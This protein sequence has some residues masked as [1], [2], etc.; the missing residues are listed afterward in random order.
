MQTSNFTVVS[1]P[2]GAGIITSAAP[3]GSPTANSTIGLLNFQLPRGINNVTENE[4]LL[5]QQVATTLGLKPSEVS[6]M[7]RGTLLL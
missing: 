4:N 7:A 1:F 2:G 3:Y 6:S 5:L